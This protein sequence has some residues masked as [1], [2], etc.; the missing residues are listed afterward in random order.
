M[1]IVM[2]SLAALA[3]VACQ[4]QDAPAD[5]NIADANA[6][7][8]M[9]AMDANAMATQAGFQI[10]DTSWEFVEDGKTVT[11]TVDSSG[12]YVA[13][14]GS[15]HLDHGTAVMKDGKACFTSAMD[16]EGEVCWTTKPVAVGESMETTNDKGETLM[17]KRV[18]FMPV[19]AAVTP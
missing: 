9:N 8:D 13:W 17:V 7:T 2:T 16:Q 15:E 4:Q 19:P 18:A 5:A 10:N 12:N 6:M 11:E 1:R 14:A 3:L